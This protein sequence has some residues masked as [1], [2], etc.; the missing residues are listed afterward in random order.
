MKILYL[1]ADDTY[2]WR[3]RLG[4]ACEARDQGFDVVLKAPVSDYRS[5]IEKEGIRVIPWKLSRRSINPFRELSSLLEVLRV[6]RRERPDIVQHETL[7]AIIHGGV[8]TRLTGHKPSVNVICGLGAIFVRSDW[9]TKVIR[10][11]LLRVLSYVFRSPNS[12]VAFQNDRDRELLVSANAVARGQTHVTP[13]N[14]VRVERFTPQPE[15]EGIPI[16]LLAARMLWEKGVGEFV[17]AAKILRERNVSVRFVLVGAPDR[18][19]PGCIP[20]EQLLSWACSG[21][22]EWWGSRADMPSVYAQSSLVCLPSY[23]GEGLPNVLA[24][25]GASGRA[26]VTTNIPGC[27]QAVTDGENGLV[28]PV[29]DPKGLAAAIQRLLEDPELRER[30]GAAGR[31]RAVQEFSHARIVGQILSIYRGL[32]DEKWP[33]PASRAESSDANA[34]VFLQA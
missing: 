22:V 9:K 29:R 13:G 1:Y 6:Y 31:R 4:L 12:Q 14:G 34:G 32:L 20:E 27:L 30:M 3:N 25:A 19:N 16:V 21:I 8:A 23:Y 2:F 28:V 10:L 11:L 5:Q 26:V 24:E 18:D 17:E 33:E 15:P 7:K